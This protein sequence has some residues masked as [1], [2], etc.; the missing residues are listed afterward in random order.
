MLGD[1]ANN[2]VWGSTKACLMEAEAAGYSHPEVLREW[3]SLAH[4]KEATAG[5]KVGAARGICARRHVCVCVLCM[6]SALVPRRLQCIIHWCLRR[7]VC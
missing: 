2:T 6:Q 7:S 1:P 3:P 5:G 4:D